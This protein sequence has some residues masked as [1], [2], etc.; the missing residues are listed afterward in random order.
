MQYMSK[1]TNIGGQCIMSNSHADEFTLSPSAKVKP[2]RVLV[3]DNFAPFLQ[4][5]ME[6]I[7]AL[8]GLEAV[9][10]ARNGEELLALCEQLQPDVVLMDIEMPLMDGV[11]ATRR[12]KQQWPQIMVIGLTGYNEMDRYQEM[13]DAGACKCLSK[14]TSA[15]ELLKHITKVMNSESG[16]TGME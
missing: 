16:P 2:I 4:S 9:G 10:A 13:L 8:A 14:T 3:A 12:I 5:L 1:R 11:T 6:L 15:S 7:Q